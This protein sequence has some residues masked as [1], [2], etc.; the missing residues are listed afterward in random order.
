MANPEEENR[1]SYSSL[2]LLPEYDLELAD[3]KKHR[4]IVFLEMSSLEWLRRLG[5]L[6]SS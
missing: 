4:F 6:W 5:S 3:L 2:P 1:L